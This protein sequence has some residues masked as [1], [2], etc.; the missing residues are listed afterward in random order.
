MR[1]KKLTVTYEDD[2]EQ[3]WE[4]PVGHVHVTSKSKKSEDYQQSV[5]AYLVLP[6]IGKVT[7]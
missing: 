5:S 1:I 2:S 6:S 4:G 7:A 3:T